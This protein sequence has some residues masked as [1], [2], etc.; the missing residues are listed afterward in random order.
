[1]LSHKTVHVVS[2]VVAVVVANL[3]QEGRMVQGMKVCLVVKKMICLVKYLKTC[4]GKSLR[5]RKNRRSKEK[6][7]EYCLLNCVV[8]LRLS[9]IVS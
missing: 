7:G 8:C 1:M 3:R 5:R 2:R 6:P 4:R 9:K